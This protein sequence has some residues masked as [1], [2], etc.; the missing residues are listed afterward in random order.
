MTLRFLEANIIEAGEYPQ[1]VQKY[2]LVRT[3]KVV[4]NET[5]SFDGALPEQLF[6]QYLLHAQE[7]MLEQPG[8]TT[9]SA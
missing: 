2:G 7:H 9:V 6:V 1:L 3:P 5:I 8:Q 4:I